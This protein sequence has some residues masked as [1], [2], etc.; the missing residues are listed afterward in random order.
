V[1]AA[2]VRRHDL[3]LDL[4]AGAGA[5]TAPLSATG[6]RVV[7]IERE[8]RLVP[9]LERR[10][11]S[12]PNVTVI[13]G[14][15]LVTPLPRRSY[16]VVANIPFAIT[17]ALL[18]RMLDE[19]APALRRADVIVQWEP[20]RRVASSRPAHPRVLWWALSYELVVTRRLGRNCFGPAP[21]VD[22][23]VLTA[24]RRARELAPS[25][26]ER[27]ALLALV[28]SCLEDSHAPVAAALRRAFSAR[29]AA[30]AL[31]DGAS[32]ATRRSA[33]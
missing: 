5:L 28:T 9:R 14:D 4:G 33:L 19:P 3:V 23:A 22:A 32:R 10:F 1:R 18:G 11:A 27:R 20:A 16:R 24:R 7:A 30:R 13:E 26:R 21:R 31:R 15:V 29:Q 12:F 17:T 6:A 2:D 8:P 25:P